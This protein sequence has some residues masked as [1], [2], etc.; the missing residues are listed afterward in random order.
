ML[1]GPD[2]ESAAELLV[3]KK[4][5]DVSPISGASSGQPQAEDYLATHQ[6]VI[7]SSRVVGEAVEKDNLRSLKCFR[8]EDDL[9]N[10]IILTLSVNRGSR[11]AGGAYSNVLTLSFRG[12]G[13]E[14]CRTVVNAIIARYQDFLQDTYRNINSETLKLIT[15]A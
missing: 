2:Y 9:T 14:D 3:I 11:K 13:A 4:H 12:K 1:K 5:L 6:A 10:A 15:Q 8:N 7:L